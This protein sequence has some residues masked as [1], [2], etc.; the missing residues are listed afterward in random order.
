MS[1]C[2]ST[3]TTYMGGF[4]IILQL[5][6][7]P[8]VA[9]FASFLLLQPQTHL[10]EDWLTLGSVIIFLVIT[11]ITVCGKHMGVG[12]ISIILLYRV[13][14]YRFEWVCGYANTSHS[15][16][17]TANIAMI[18]SI[19][20]FK[21]F[22]IYTDTILHPKKTSSTAHSNNGN[23]VALCGRKV[24]VVLSLILSIV[25]NY[26]NACETKHYLLYNFIQST[27]TILFFVTFSQIFDYMNNFNGI[28]IG[29]ERLATCF[30][31]MV[32]PVKVYIFQICVFIV[33][34]V[35]FHMDF[36][37]S[38]IGKYNK[39]RDFTVME[40]NTIFS[41][42]DSEDDDLLEVNIREFTEDETTNVSESPYSITE[43]TDSPLTKTSEPLASTCNTGST[44]A[45][46]FPLSSSSPEWRKRRFSFHTSEDTP[47]IAEHTDD[48]ERQWESLMEGSVSE[49]L[50]NDD[51]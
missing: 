6:V 51:K 49:P 20:V 1:S 8:L 4:E 12:Y 2:K 27:T 47:A 7:T 40:D 35:I 17:L 46:S 44:S 26:M 9:C 50:L 5:I 18:S 25:L 38:L 48:E 10:T 19:F 29:S 36:F 39:K 42:N 28:L 22:A 16:I 45:C 41:L 37:F 11:I 31:A 33:L 3:P 43:T 24:L 23:T 14:Y 13:S 15:W 34:I 32:S 30:L 21:A